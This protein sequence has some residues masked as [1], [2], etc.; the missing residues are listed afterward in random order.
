MK[1]DT[2]IGRVWLVPDML[3]Y[4]GAKVHAQLDLMWPT[5][6]GFVALHTGPSRGGAFL[7]RAPREAL[8]A[9]GLPTGS[10]A[11]RPVADDKVWPPSDLT[12]D[13]R[14]AFAEAPAF[15]DERTP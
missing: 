6:D 12:D 8:E 3:G 4:K 1:Q 15:N 10:A 13:E 5:I 11:E 9:R 2:P 14:Q 7:V